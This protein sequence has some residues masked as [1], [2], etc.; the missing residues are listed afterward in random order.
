MYKTL[1]QMQQ[2]RYYLKQNHVYR[3]CISCICHSEAED[4]TVSPEPTWLR[5]L[6]GTRWM[7]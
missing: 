5:K 7:K 4:K 6:N 2:M 1:H 3:Y